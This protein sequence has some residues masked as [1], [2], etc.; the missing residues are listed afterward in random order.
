MTP[1]DAE[2]AVL[3]AYAMTICGLSAVGGRW[4][5]A[6]FCRTSRRTGWRGWRHQAAR[7]GTALNFPVL[8]HPAIVLAANR[9]LPWAAPLLPQLRQSLVQ[10]GGKKQIIGRQ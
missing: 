8:G 1:A 3:A 10:I 4:T 7:A 2:T 9:P 6:P 5:E